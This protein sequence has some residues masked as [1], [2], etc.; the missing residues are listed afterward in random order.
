M[1]VKRYRGRHLIV[2]PRHRGAVAVG[3]ASTV[4]LSASA[5]HAGTHVVR[6][7]ETLSS[8]ASRYRTSVSRLVAVND[9]SNPNF[10]AAGQRL[11]VPGRGGNSHRIHKVRAGETLST[12]AAK[13]GTSTGA[14]ARK[15]K[16]ANPNFIVA[17]QKLK[18]PRN[19]SPSRSRSRG[20]PPPASVSSIASSLQNQS[21]AH[22]VDPSLTKAVAWVESGWRQNVRSRTGAIGVMQIMPGTARHINRDLGGHDLNFRKPDDNVHLGV[23]YLRHL[24]RILPTTAKALAGYYSGPGNVGRRLKGYQRYYVRMVRG[25]RKRFR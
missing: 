17:G 2:R 25:A 11:R 8:I 14:L 18:V 9:L 7:G 10:I 5:A 3:A 12:I 15:N 24:K 19:G 16:L 13:Y 20:V 22:G 6:P 4:W 21:A 23:M 1:R